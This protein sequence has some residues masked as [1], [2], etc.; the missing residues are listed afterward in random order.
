MTRT[1]D[2]KHIEDRLD[3]IEKKIDDHIEWHLNHKD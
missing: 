2:L 3:K 1:N